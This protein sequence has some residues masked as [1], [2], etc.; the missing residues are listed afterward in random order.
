MNAGFVKRENVFVEF[1]FFQRSLSIDHARKGVGE[2]RVNSRMIEVGIDKLFQPGDV[3]VEIGTEASGGSPDQCLCSG[4]VVLT[5]EGDSLV[6][7]Q[8]REDLEGVGSR[9]RVMFLH[10]GVQVFNR[11][12]LGNVLGWGGSVDCEVEEDSGE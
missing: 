1:S 2:N 10:C 7:V 12:E 4:F 9:S 11:G 5:Q 6:F 8:K 3:R